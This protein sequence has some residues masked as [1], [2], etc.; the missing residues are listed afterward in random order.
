MN[1]KEYLKQIRLLDI[2]INYRLEE[3][4]DLEWISSRYP[5]ISNRCKELAA[6]IDNVIRDLVNRK[7]EIIGKILLL[8]DHRYSDVL[9]LHY[10]RYILLEDVAAVM[11]KSNG[12]HY[13]FQHI[14][15]L[16]SEA[17]N[18]IQKII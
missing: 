5:G 12:K 10:A 18:E 16:H 11:M 14:N 6:G 3:K 1:A 8:K 9:F 17:L 4:E 13:T 7:D 15:R 2:Q